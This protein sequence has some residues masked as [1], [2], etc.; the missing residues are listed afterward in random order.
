MIKD[1]IDAQTNP[2][3][4]TYAK[5]AECDIRV[6]ARARNEAEA[7]NFQKIGLILRKLINR[8]SLAVRPET[9][10]YLSRSHSVRRKQGC[11]KYDICS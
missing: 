4:A 3:I 10:R 7:E 6:T 11:R 8:N 5:T 1:L 2:T 9:V